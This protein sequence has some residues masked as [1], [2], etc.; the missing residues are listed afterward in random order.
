M[1]EDRDRVY[2][3]L[4]GGF[5]GQRVLVVGDLIL[6]RYLWGKVSRISPE[7][8]VP[9][10]HLERENYTGGGGANVALN[11]K[12]LGLTVAVAG[13]VGD[14]S[15]GGLLVGHLKNAGIDTVAIQ[16]LVDH[17]TV[18]KTRVI[19]GHQ[20]MLRMDREV[21]VPVSDKSIADLLTAVL[22]QLTNGPAIVILSDYAKG[23]LTPVVCRETI[24]SARESGIPILVDPKGEDYHKYIGATGI[25]P[26][27]QE[28]AAACGTSGDDLPLLLD[29]GEK[30]RGRLELDFIVATLGEI[31]IALMDEVHEQRVPAVA[32]EVF[33]VSG[34]GD[35]VIATLAAGLAVQLSRMDAVHLANLAASVVV[36]KVGTAPIHREELQA[37]ASEESL[38][39]VS[40]KVC[41]LE[42]LLVRVEKWRARG[43]RVVFTNGC[44]D[45]L[46][47]G[48]V[49]LL[50]HAKRMGSR[51]VVGLNTDRSVRAIKGKPRPIMDQDDRA[52]VLAALASVDA[53]VLFD[54][55]TPI[56]LIT[57]IRPDVLAKGADYTEDQVVGAQEVRSWGGRIDLIPLVDGK[58]SSHI[59]QALGTANSGSPK[60]A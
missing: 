26:N 49:T 17:P 50:E 58:S 44:F 27:R 34:A 7:A 14:D 4:D 5:Y 56:D 41:S 45:L 15:E 47:A 19:G 42:E 37:A 51:L 48:H 57:A 33:D 59:I 20:Q 6:D 30:L 22:R 54:E 21:L 36:G 55:E 43:D 31:G 13:Y 11:L 10:V 24:A 2:Q 3:A 18:T 23:V 53:V 25:C 1:F 29:A 40:D 16:T 9:V 46:H 60:K 52:R 28:L 39:N 32:R 35:T 12:G 38:Q 8:P